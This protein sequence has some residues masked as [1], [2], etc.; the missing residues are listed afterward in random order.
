MPT[1]HPSDAQDPAAG[2]DDDSGLEVFDGLVTAMKKL[3]EHGAALPDAER[4]EQA[5]QLAA[6]FLQTLGGSSSEGEEE[7]GAR[8][9]DAV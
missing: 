7:E 5:A 8:G 6:K 9:K 1:V 3:K 2:G 4:K